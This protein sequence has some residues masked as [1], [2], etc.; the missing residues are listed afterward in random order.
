M[1]PLLP[2]VLGVLTVEPQNV[3]VLEEQIAA[4]ECAAGNALP[5]ASVIWYKDSLPFNVSSSNRYYMSDVTGTLFI[6]DARA[7]DEGEYSCECV[8]SVGSVT[9]V[10]AA[11]SVVNSFQSK[12]LVISVTL[13][14]LL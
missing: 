4:F 3:T 11:L 13:Q 1:F 14:S 7:S 10:P 9:S 6:R 2:A 8:N 5:R 12:L